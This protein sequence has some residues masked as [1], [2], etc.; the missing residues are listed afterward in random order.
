MQHADGSWPWFPGGP[1][2]DYITLYI[3]TGYGRLRHLGVKIDTAP[4]VKSIARLDGWADRI[5][6]DILRHGKP[7]DNHLSPTI[8]LYLYGRSFF[9]QDAPVA[10]PQLGEPFGTRRAFC[11]ATGLSEDLLSHVMARRKHLSMSS[12]TDALHRIG[13]ALHIGP[14]PQRRTGHKP[15]T[16]YRIKQRPRPAS[17]SPS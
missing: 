5:Y 17:S 3:T 12:L 1:G 15:S 7:D 9:L 10:P 16:A 8:A 6:R 13:Y 2:N 11:Q 14:A 4:A